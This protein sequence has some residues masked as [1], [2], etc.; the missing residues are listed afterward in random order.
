MARLALFLRCYRYRILYLDGKIEDACSGSCARENES[1]KYSE[2]ANDLQIARAKPPLYLDSKVRAQRAS[3]YDINCRLSYGNYLSV[4]TRRAIDRDSR[5]RATPKAEPLSRG[6]H[7]ILM[8][9]ARDS[10]RRIA[11]I[12]PRADF[13]AIR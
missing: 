10:L 1:V 7:V 11:V 4:C 13:I 2:L 12:S 9:Y 8:K 5:L 6:V 3:C